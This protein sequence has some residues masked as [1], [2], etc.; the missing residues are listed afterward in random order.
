MSLL[1]ERVDRVTCYRF[2]DSQ[3]ADGPVAAACQ[4]A[5]VSTSAYYDWRRAQ[6]SKP[7]PAQQAEH[8]LVTEI[9]SVH[10]A[11]DGTYGSPRVHAELRRRG[12]V[13]NHKRVERLMRAHDLVGVNPRKRVPTT[14]PADQPEPAPDLLGR[15]FMPGLPDQRWL[16]SVGGSS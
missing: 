8:G 4:A 9:H 16:S 1:G 3:K 12:W 6:A 10:E 15:D 11:S 14:V 7:S 2:V 13:V 5:G